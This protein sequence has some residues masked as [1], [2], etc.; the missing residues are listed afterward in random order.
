MLIQ[1]GKYKIVV[2]Y[3]LLKASTYLFGMMV[4]TGHNVYVGILGVFKL[5]VELL[6]GIRNL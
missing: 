5:C 3:S 2:F 1:I 4:C 6:D